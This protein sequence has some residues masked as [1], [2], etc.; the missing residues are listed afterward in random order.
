MSLIALDPTLGKFQSY[1][2]ETISSTPIMGSDTPIKQ[3]TIDEAQTFNFL[4]NLYYMGIGV[5]LTSIKSDIKD[6]KDSDSYTMKFAN[7]DVTSAV[8]DWKVFLEKCE[9]IRTSGFGGVSQ[10]KKVVIDAELKRIGGLLGVSIPLNKYSPSNL[11]EQSSSIDNLTR[12]VLNTT[13]LISG[14]VND[15]NVL[16]SEIPPYDPNKYVVSNEEVITEEVIATQQKTSKS[17][18]IK[19][20]VLAIVGVIGGYL[21]FKKK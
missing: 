20:A 19:W 3:L 11:V 14:Y 5:S 16:I 13:G 10:N 6:K 9:N 4:V 7:G 1:S 8:G 21:M 17:N 12:M 15:F 18:N 2:G